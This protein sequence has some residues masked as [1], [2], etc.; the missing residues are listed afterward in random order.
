MGLK[1]NN[2]VLELREIHINLY[3]VQTGNIDFTIVVSTIF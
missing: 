2:L 1:N 3:K